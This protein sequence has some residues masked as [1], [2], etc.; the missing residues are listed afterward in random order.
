M[1]VVSVVS[2]RPPLIKAAPVCK[3]LGA[4][5]YTEEQKG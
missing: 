2:A 5:R 1:K 4:A 3:A